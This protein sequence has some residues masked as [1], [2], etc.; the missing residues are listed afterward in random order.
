M[1][2]LKQKS[3][4]FHDCVAD[5]LNRLHNHLEE[6]GVSEEDKATRLNLLLTTYSQFHTMYIGKST[7]AKELAK[8]EL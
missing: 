7:L 3:E 5:H 1:A 8:R 6:Q 2:T 4:W